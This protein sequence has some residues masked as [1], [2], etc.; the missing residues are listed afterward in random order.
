MPLELELV[1]LD[2]AAPPDEEEVEDVVAGLD[3]WVDELEDC[4]AG[5]DAGVD[6]LEEFEPHAAI[7]RAANS[8]KP[9]ASRRG[10]LVI[11]MVLMSRS[12][13]LGQA[14][15]H[16]PDASSGVVIPE[17]VSRVSAQPGKKRRLK[18]SLE[19]ANRTLPD[20]P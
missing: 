20:E 8:S 18:A 1:E 15:G 13:V 14:L 19:A 6:E 17:T 11:E 10:N 16:L 4:G 2:G 3:D 12:L 7:P 5:L 9:A